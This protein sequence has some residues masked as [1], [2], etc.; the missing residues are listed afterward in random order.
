[1]NII[2][3]ALLVLVIFLIFVDNALYV[4]ADDNKAL[5]YDYGKTVL[6]ENSNGTYTLDITNTYKYTKDGQPIINEWY[7]NNGYYYNKNNTFKVI[8][9]INSVNISS[10]D[11][12]LIYNPVVT[13]NKK[14]IN[15]IDIYLDS[16]RS[17]IIDYGILTRELWLSGGVLCGDWLI[18]KEIDNT[19]NIKYNQ[20]GNIY[21]NLG[22]NKLDYDSENI[23]VSKN[24]LRDSILQ[25][26]LYFNPDSDTETN[27]V[28]GYIQRYVATETWASLHDSVAGTE[29]YDSTLSGDGIIEIH[30]S[31]TSNQWRLNKRGVFLF[32][33]SLIPD[34]ACIQS[35]NI[36][37]YGFNKGSTY[38]VWETNMYG[39]I[40]E[41]SPN[42]DT[43]LSINDYSNFSFTALSNGILYSGWNTSGYNIFNLNSTGLNLI[44]VSGIS[45]FGI[46]SYYDLNDISPTW[47]SG[48]YI[49]MSSYFS[50]K[51]DGYEPILSVTFTTPPNEP[52]NVT[53]TQT[54]NDTVNILWDDDILSDN[55]TLFLRFADNIW[56]NLYD[57]TSENYTLDG[58]DLNN[59]IYQFKLLSGNDCGISDYT[60]YNIDF[61]FGGET[62]MEIIHLLSLIPLLALFAMSMIWYGRGL[63]HITLFAYSIT[64]AFVAISGSWELL[65][66]PLLTGTAIIA[67]LLF[68]YAMTKGNWL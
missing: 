32:D 25:D 49:Y 48:K 59:T 41:S 29:A 68:V 10:G 31:T 6:T 52:T 66:F 67:L 50:D 57:G 51:G 17:L 61:I 37:L 45:K 16:D 8:V 13:I 1:M 38:A 5:T 26:T 22:S 54:D 42:S 27:T 12:N 33:T 11:Y 15:P 7:L 34:N 56:Y 62:P 47:I 30:S 2:K 23:T 28:D 53:I 35:A 58:L 21:L 44:N 18:P 63:I 14:I 4:K 9:D 20:V 64:L 55:T 19:V 36:S 43:S 65:F 3:N 46:M 60:I 39:Y 24:N 40:I